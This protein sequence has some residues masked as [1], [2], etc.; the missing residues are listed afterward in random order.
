MEGKAVAAEEVEVELVVS[1]G[2]GSKIRL[3][4]NQCILLFLMGKVMDL[5]KDIWLVL[6]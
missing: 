1:V 4:Y 6:C 2:L 5:C 3:R